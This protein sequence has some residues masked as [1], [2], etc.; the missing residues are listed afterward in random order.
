MCDSYFIRT[1]RK[2]ESKLWLNCEGTSTRMEHEEVAFSLRPFVLS[3]PEPGQ[4]VQH[5]VGI[6]HSAFR[7]TFGAG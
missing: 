3:L 4:V 2:V 1:F 6:V 7:A 5:G